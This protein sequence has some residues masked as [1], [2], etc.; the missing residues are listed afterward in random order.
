[1]FVYYFFLIIILSGSSRNTIIPFHSTEFERC[2][3]VFK[4]WISLKDTGLQFC[5]L[6]MSADGR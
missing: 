4:K 1:M 2:D 6:D 5:V 3:K